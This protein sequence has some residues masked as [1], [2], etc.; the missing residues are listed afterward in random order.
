MN[1]PAPLG[2]MPLDVRAGS[3]LP[4]G[5]AV[6]Y[7]GEKP[8]A[9]IELRIYPGADGNFALYEDDGSTYNY[10]KGARSIILIRWDDSAHKLTIGGRQGSF[11]G[12]AAQRTFNIVWVSSGHGAG[13]TSARFFDKTVNYNGAPV[14]I[15]P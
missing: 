4:L 8:N 1:A 13:V 9:P 2:T 5:P 14:T 6:Q 10:E 11:P 15:H 3:I 7:T 12:M